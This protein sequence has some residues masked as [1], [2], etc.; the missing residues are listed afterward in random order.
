[1][2]RKAM[3]AKAVTQSSKWL[4]CK[5]L[6]A[7]RLQN[8][9]HSQ[10][11]SSTKELDQSA[12]QALG[13]RSTTLASSLTAQSLILRWPAVS[14]S[15][16]LSGKAKWSEAGT[17]TSLSFKRVRKPSSPAHLPTHTEIEALAMWSLPTLRFYS[18]LSSL[19]S[20]GDEKVAVAFI[21]AYKEYSE[22]RSFEIV[23]W[24]RDDIKAKIS[25][26]SHFSLSKWYLSHSRIDIETKWILCWSL[27]NKKQLMFLI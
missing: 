5:I 12:H 10:S 24:L 17:R 8:K 23:R 15:S 19:T 4:V 22:M 1:M 6:M 3:T 16:L 11:K 25:A 20:E 7:R 26:Y 2:K 21:R 9:C 27:S 18:R 14:L 13:L